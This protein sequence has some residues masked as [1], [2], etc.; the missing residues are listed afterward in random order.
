MGYGILHVFW[1]S[2]VFGGPLVAMGVFMGWGS[3]QILVSV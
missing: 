1:A 2:A 3:W